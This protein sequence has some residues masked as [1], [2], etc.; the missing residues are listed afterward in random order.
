M[1]IKTILKK[2]QNL[3]KLQKTTLISV[4][5]T[6][7]IQE[8]LKV[9]NQGQRDFGENY[10]EEILEKSEKLPKDINWHYIGHLQSNKVNKLLQMNL[11]YFH[12]LDS[13]KLS[14]KINN[15]LKDKKKT[16]KV[17]IQVN[18][19]E[20]VSKNGCSKNEVEDL[21]KFVKKNCEF[22]NLIG[23]MMIGGKGIKKEFDDLRIL[24]DS[25]DKNLELS[26]G[27]SGDYEDAILCGSNYVRVGSLIFGP[28]NYH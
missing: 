15:K 18:I 27:M 7:S 20:E 2:I 3:K 17:F 12:T 21:V 25:I 16:M 8:I 14:K 4:S 22:L 1:E 10:V 23:F 11:T 19:S 26:M 9:Y 24:R 13:I 5:K 6:R 28:R